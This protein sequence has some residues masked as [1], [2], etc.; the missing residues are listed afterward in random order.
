MRRRKSNRPHWL[1]GKKVFKTTKR[2][3]KPQQH[4][5]DEEKEDYNFVEVANNG[6]GLVK[7]GSRNGRCE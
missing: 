7:G 5:Q 4:Q 3:R 1:S 6:N 2:R